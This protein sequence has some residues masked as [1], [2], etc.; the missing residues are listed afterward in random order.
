MEKLERFRMNEARKI[1]KDVDTLDLGG[2]TGEPTRFVVN[3]EKMTA[4]DL[5][6]DRLKANPAKNKI[7]ADI[8]KLP[9]KDNSFSQ[10]TLFEVIEHIQ[11]ASKREE[12]FKEIHRVL[13]KEGTFI[14][15]T[16]NYWRASTIARKIIGKP[17]KYPYATKKIEGYEATGFHYF[18][19]PKK[20]LVREL[21]QIGFG[22]INIYDRYLHIPFTK[23]FL[24]C[25]N[26]LGG[27]IYCIAQKK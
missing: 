23:I 12:I 5:N 26:C 11:E 16:P 1:L 8:S 3:P 22:R 10:A 20:Q 18:E 4:V 17:R 7:A 21:K 19:Y 25:K 13:K 15:S 27:T 14:I 9:F 6:K 2:G 24:N